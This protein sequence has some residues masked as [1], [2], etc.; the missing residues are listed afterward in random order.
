MLSILNYK[1]AI[2]EFIPPGPPFLFGFYYFNIDLVIFFPLLFP[3][4]SARSR[5]YH[6]IGYIH[7]RLSALALRIWQESMLKIMAS[8]ARNLKIMNAAQR[9]Q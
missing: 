2:T 9:D 6:F 7:M 4:V 5:L 3:Y 1:C 8:R